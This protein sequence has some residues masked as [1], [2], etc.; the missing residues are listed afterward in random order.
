MLQLTVKR[1]EGMVGISNT[2][3]VAGADFKEKILEQVPE[4]PETNIIIEPFGRDTAAAIGLSALVFSRRDP[5]EVMIVLP[6]DHYISDDDRFLEILRGAVVAAG[7]GEKIV[8]LGITPHRPETGYGYIYRGELLDDFAGVSAYRVVRFLEKPDY[9]RAVEFL[10]D[11]NYLWNSGM[12]VWRVDL[13]NKLMNIHTPQLAKGLKKIEE[14]FGSESYPEVLEEVYAGL[15]RIS[16][17]YS[18]LEKADNVLVMPGDFGWDDIGSWNALE[19]YASKDDYG[20]VLDGQGI[21]LDTNDTYVFSRD[22]TVAVM[23]VDNLIVVNDRDSL[24]ICRKNRA[25][26]V[27]KVIQALRSKGYDTVL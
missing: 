21:M 27:K 2:F 7:R 3:I 23:G 25:Q 13:I 17:D 8:T 9:T 1:I 16:V 26:E 15:P 5:R 19:R 12:F 22:K 10:S 14:A 18:I 20:N 24:L 11:G 6:A 4:L